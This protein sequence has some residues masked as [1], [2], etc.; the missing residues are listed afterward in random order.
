MEQI[1]NIYNIIKED[2]PDLLA[3]TQQGN[4]WLWIGATWPGYFVPVA[5]IRCSIGESDIWLDMIYLEDGVILSDY[6]DRLRAH[7]KMSGLKHYSR[8]AYPSATIKQIKSSMLG[9]LDLCNWIK[10]EWDPA[11]SD[12]MLAELGF[13]RHRASRRYDLIDNTTGIT[14]ITPYF[15]QPDFDIPSNVDIDPAWVLELATPAT[16]VEQAFV[17]LDDLLNYIA[18]S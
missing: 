6:L 12:K 11:S 2:C 5:N 16:Y 14:V 18:N 8:H 15:V 1:D 13:E 9:W 3:Y 4:N 17:S 7:N 10:G